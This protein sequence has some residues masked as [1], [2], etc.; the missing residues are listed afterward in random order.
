MPR[1][2]PA[3]V[4]L[5]CSASVAGLASPGWAQDRRWEVQVSVGPTVMSQPGAG[6]TQLPE[7]GGA[8]PSF[9]EHRSRTVP[10]WLFGDGTTLANQADAQVRISDTPL[11]PL[12]AILTASALR[13]RVLPGV[14]IRIARQVGSRYAI[15][16]AVAYYGLTYE[17]PDTVPAAIE[18]SRLSFLGFWGSYAAMVPNGGHVTAQARHTLPE[19][20][21][22][23]S[24]FALRTRVHHTARSSLS[25]IVGGGLR[26]SFGR[27]ATA[28]IEARY[29]FDVFS[30]YVETDA[31][32]LEFDVE[33]QVPVALLGANW[34]VRTSERVGIALDVRTHLGRSGV[35]TRLETRPRRT[36]VAPGQGALVILGVD[37]SVYISN[38]SFPT[39][40][41]DIPLS[42]FVTYHSTGVRAH[43]SA[44]VGLLLR[45]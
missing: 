44:S 14:G 22:V 16:G 10:S 33:R 27:P 18:A 38:S 7:P 4:V 28:D 19:T 34:Q 24:T 30:R 17:L 15:E 20:R 21:Q 2:R 25:A 41:L 26:S 9:A 23:L 11:V 43:T 31:V 39:S 37:P 36:L 13:P 32:T 42:G 45:F 12:D 40:S 5:M 3:A 8:L 6:V 1:V 35:S 29:L